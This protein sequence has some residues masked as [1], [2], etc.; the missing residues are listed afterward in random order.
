MNLKEQIYYFDVLRALAIIGI[1]LLHSA[2][3][4]LYEFNN[5]SAFD[6]HVANFYDSIAR[7]SV[8]IFFMISGYLN[9]NSLENNES[10]FLFYKNRFIKVVIPFVFWAICYFLLP[11]FLDPN[12]NIIQVLSNVNNYKE[13][14]YQLLFGPVYYHLWFIYTILV[15]YL[16]TPLIKKALSLFSKK[17]FAWILILFF[18]FISINNILNL[19]FGFSYN[20]SG[21]ASTIGYFGYGLLFIGYYILGY[22]LESISKCNLKLFN[23]IGIAGLFITI[24][25]TYLLTLE[26]KG[27]FNEFFYHYLNFNT[28]L[29]SVWIFI[30]F[31]CKIKK[32]PTIILLLSEYSFGIYLIHILIIELLNKLQ[33]NITLF[34]PIFSIPIFSIVVLILSFLAVWT[35]SKVPILKRIVP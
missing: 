10:I 24:I 32:C 4:L 18:S 6:W 3:P 13:F 5:I 33:I 20:T 8:P 23:C 17:T 34:S 12:I 11:F 15:L 26:N 30:L 16:F 31:K 25:G 19:I 21:I 28:L 9:L 7:W 29:V 1:V 27:I 2:T 22:F 35:L 14:I